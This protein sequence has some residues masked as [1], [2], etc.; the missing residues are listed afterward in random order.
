METQQV[1]YLLLIA[2]TRQLP[3]F[4]VIIIGIVLCFSNRAKSPKASKIALSGLLILLLTY[5]LGVALFLIQ[6]YLPILM[7]KSGNEAV[8]ISSALGI[9]FSLLPAIGLGLIIY[10]VWAGRDK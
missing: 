5:F 10:A 1:L 4:I 2:F 7:N 8:Y 3:Q 6:I 9:L